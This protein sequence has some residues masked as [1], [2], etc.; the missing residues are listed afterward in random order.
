MMSTLLYP[1]VTFVL[2]LVC[3]AYWGIT[4]LYPVCVC[5][6]VCMHVCVSVI[7]HLCVC[8]S[9]SMRMCVCLSVCAC[10]SVSMC[11]CGGWCVVGGGWW[12]VRGAGGGDYLQP[13]SPHPQLAASKPLRG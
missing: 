9:V 2:V 4:A 3:V 1:L 7:M 10:V 11:V 5:L 6:S 12:V 8:V 13:P